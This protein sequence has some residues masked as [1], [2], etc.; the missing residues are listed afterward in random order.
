MNNISSSTAKTGQ[1]Q[2]HRVAVLK[3][4][5]TLDGISPRMIPA[6]LPEK[7]YWKSVCDRV[8]RLHYC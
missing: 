5:T 1:R 4:Q 6:T 2:G 7:S 8:S 3:L